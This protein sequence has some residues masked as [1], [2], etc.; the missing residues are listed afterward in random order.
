MCAS[1]D[2]LLVIQ[3]KMIH[4]LFKP[5]LHVLHENCLYEKDIA[6]KHGLSFQFYIPLVSFCI[7]FFQHYYYFT[8][9][10]FTHLKMVILTMKLI[11]PF[12]KSSQYI[13]ALLTCMAQKRSTRQWHTHHCNATYKSLNVIGNPQS[14][15]VCVCVFQRA[16]FKEGK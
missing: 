9:L 2:C 8:I 11:V 15:C 5:Q 13:G 6:A 16:Y 1:V 4:S 12:G 3:Q 7:F 10:V 14:L